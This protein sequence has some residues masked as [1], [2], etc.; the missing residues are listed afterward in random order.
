VREGG[1]CE[2]RGK[3]P[4][5]DPA[6]GLRHAVLFR[7]GLGQPE[8]AVEDAELFERRFS[9]SRPRMT[10]EVVFAIG[11]VHQR[12]ERWS[13]LVAHYR[14]FL[15]RYARAATPTQL[16]RAHVLVARGWIRQG[17]RARAE[18]HLRAAV[19]IRE[20]GGEEAIAR[21]DGLTEE[22]RHALVVRLRDVVAEARYELA[23]ALRERFEAER[24]PALRGAASLARVDR[25]AGRE[26]APW[27]ARKR[28]LLRAAE[29]AYA[30]IAPLEVPRW[31]IA[32]AS[33]IGDMFYGLVQQV[34]RSP[35]PAVIERVPEL[36]DAY[37]T[38]LDGAV[39][40]LE[41]IAVARYESCLATATRVRWFD[42]RSRRCERALN[43]LDAARFPV[44]S[45][46]RGAP[47]YS[48]L[49]PARPGPVELAEREG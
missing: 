45:E 21:L 4:C 40:P 29:E 15:R 10:A 3:D 5:P 28:E 7:L 35:I 14:S 17:R 36:Y 18:D 22:E 26:L 44:A 32:A 1:R 12:A 47:R 49:A 11:A 20:R 25:W 13:R 39:A 30:Q 38:A 41:A 31:R 43:R 37:V 27:L 19:E 16:A 8:R 46:L 42:E 33:R 9:R 23:E 24:F 2:P 34:R 48:P 6:D